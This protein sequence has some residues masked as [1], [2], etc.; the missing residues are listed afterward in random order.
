MAGAL[1]FE[2]GE[3]AAGSIGSWMSV[4]EPGDCEGDQPGKS[5]NS[6]D[7]PE[8]LGDQGSV[9]GQPGES[10]SAGNNNPEGTASG[11]DCKHQKGD[12]PTSAGSD[13]LGDTEPGHT[14]V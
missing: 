11:N 2:A 13:I 3:I 1:G 9:H 7:N 6:N 12:Q 14:E 4:L 10:T 8:D 5:G